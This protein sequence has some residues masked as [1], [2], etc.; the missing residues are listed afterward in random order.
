MLLLALDSA[1]AACSV[2][3]WDASRPEPAALLGHRR[4]SAPRSQ[5]DRL[6]ELVDDLMQAAQLDY[7]A[8]GVIAVDHGPGSFTGLRSAVAAARGLALAADLPVL[9]VSS[10]EALAAALP[11]G[12]TGTL[13]AALDARRGQVYWQAFDHRHEPRTAPSVTTP[14]RLPVELA[15]GPLRLVGSGAPLI[16]AALPEGR[17]VA[18]ESAELDAR[19]VAR[20]AARR[21]AHGEVPQAGS[22]LRPLYLRPPDARPR[23]PLVAPARAEAVEA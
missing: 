19:W 21:L 13:V 4:L 5:A 9:G 8:L 17:P 23:T 11:E 18:I 7:R 12:A 6:V 14:D 10:L 1:E 20:R 3:L 2:A 22:S 15:P 16:R